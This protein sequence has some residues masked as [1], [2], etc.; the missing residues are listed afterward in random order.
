MSCEDKPSLKRKR[1]PSPTQTAKKP[2]T[3][4]NPFDYFNSTS[5]KELEDYEEPQIEIQDYQESSSEPELPTPSKSPSKSP[6]QSPQKPIP[7][8]TPQTTKKP[9]KSLQEMIKKPSKPT[10]AAKPQ[11]FSVKY[12]PKTIQDLIGNSSQIKKLKDWLAN[13]P[14]YK[15]AVLLSG[16]PGI[17]KTTS[18]RIIAKSMQY[19]PIEFNA[20]DTRSKGF[21]HEKISTFCLNTSMK[22]TESVTNGLLIMDEVDGMSAG[23]EGG[24]QALIEVLKATKVPVICICNDRYSTKV[25]SLTSY[26]LD[27]RFFKPRVEEL[28]NKLRT[29]IQ[30]EK[31]SITK[32][33]ATEIAELSG[34]DVRQMLNLLEMAAKSSNFDVKSA[35]KDQSVALTAFDAASLLLNKTKNHTHKEKIDTVLVDYEMVPLLVSENYQQACSLENLSEAADSI[36]F[37]DLII[38]RIKTN[39]EWVLLPHYAQS[40]AVAPAYFTEVPIEKLNFPK[41]LGKLSNFNK[42]LRLAQELR[43][44]ISLASYGVQ[45]ETLGEYSQLIANYAFKLAK[46]KDSEKL[47][48]FMTDYRL[49][50][51]LVKDHLMHFSDEPTRKT[52]KEVSRVFSKLLNK[53]VKQL[54]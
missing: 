22:S 28:F 21:I 26:C 38:N 16:P 43:Q 37:S 40:A 19:S 36:A 44:H 30:L 45:N 10:F 50:W 41:V 17:G 34:G 31:V 11:P 47:N 52:C 6:P 15:R 3:E 5:V 14:K 51:D 42:S 8:N 53:G 12:A 23:D 9:I 7:Q 39:Q 29:I 49:N 27:V 2:K 46:E 4:I 25:K 13:W 33:K 1:D 48:Q 32:P 35:G 20:S 24:M 54:I 18:A